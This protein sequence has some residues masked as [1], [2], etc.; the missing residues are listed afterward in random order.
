M[1]SVTQQAKLYSE[2]PTTLADVPVTKYYRDRFEGPTTYPSEVVSFLTMGIKK[3]WNTH[4][5]IE[6]VWNTDTHEWDEYYGEQDELI[7]NIT[8]WDTSESR[9][10]LIT[11][12]LEKTIKI[13]KLN[14]CWAVDHMKV[15]TFKGVSLLPPWPDEFNRVH[16]WRASIDIAVEYLWSEIE[17]APAIRSFEYLFTAGNMEVQ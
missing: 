3:H 4:A 5:S 16:P 13:D 10:Y 12:D 17:I 11:D 14:L 6:K 1:L 8:L 2:I 7:M 15:T 9:L